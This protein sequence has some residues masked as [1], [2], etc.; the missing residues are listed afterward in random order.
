MNPQH[1]RAN[2]SE[3]TIRELEALP[4]RQRKRFY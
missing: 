4:E 1:N 2:L 3:D